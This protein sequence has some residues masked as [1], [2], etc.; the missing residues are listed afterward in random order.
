MQTLLNDISKVRVPGLGQ[1]TV[2]NAG[3]DRRY[4]TQGRH[5]K[6]EK[7]AQRLLMKKL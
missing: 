7:D 4:P 2:R 1:T 6:N 5:I 3:F